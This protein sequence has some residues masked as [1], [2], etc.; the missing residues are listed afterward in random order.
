MFNYNLGIYGPTV[1]IPSTVESQRNILCTAL[2]LALSAELQYIVI[3]K[4]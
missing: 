3:V 1:N 2:T 4:Q